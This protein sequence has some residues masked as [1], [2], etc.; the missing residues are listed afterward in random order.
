MSKNKV[1]IMLSSLMLAVSPGLSVAATLTAP[2][3]HES[4]SVAPRVFYTQISND[5]A[6]VAQSGCKTYKAC[7]KLFA[8]V[9]HAGVNNFKDL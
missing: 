2:V 7:N 9:V 3:L 5:S 6:Y 1:F 4:T 8:G